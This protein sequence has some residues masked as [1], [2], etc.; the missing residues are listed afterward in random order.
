MWPETWYRTRD[1]K[2][3]AG[4]TMINTARFDAAGR[5]SSVPVAGMP[6]RVRASRV[7]AW[8]RLAGGGLLTVALVLTA[9]PAAP[10]TSP[11]PAAASP[12]RGAPIRSPLTLT[13]L[14][15]P[16]IS[17]V[18]AA[19]AAT[20]PERLIQIPLTAP[21][22]YAA[23]GYTPVNFT[24]LARFLIAEPAPG[25]AAAASEQARW[26]EVLRQIPTEIRELDGKKVAV[27]GYMLAVSLQNG[28]TDE[29]L[30]LRNQSVCCF[31]MV[32]RVNELIL[33][34]T[35][36]PGVRPMSDVPVSVA[37]T[38]QLKQI[39]EAGSLTGIYEMTAERVESSEPR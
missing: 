30:L 15:R 12:L 16:G 23:L 33:V 4:Q 5:G 1:V 38:L 32:P 29:F 25:T 22:K 39:G 19:S 6:S 8:H 26:T 10:P 28:L 2:T 34:K 3:L 21:R 18:L 14:T 7:F 37:G 27:T 9:A 35:A 11:A 17:N 31:G 36:P 13:N 20:A 24:T